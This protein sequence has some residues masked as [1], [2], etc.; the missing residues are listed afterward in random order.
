MGLGRYH[1]FPW[2]KISCSFHPS[3]LA[4]IDMYGV[5]MGIVKPIPES[6]RGSRYPDIKELWP[7]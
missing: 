1:T 2:A 6:P 3:R 5:P 4:I 7:W